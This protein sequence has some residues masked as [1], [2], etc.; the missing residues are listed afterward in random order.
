M[1]QTPKCAT[2]E[3]FLLEIFGAPKKIKEIQ[4]ATGG[5][6]KKRISEIYDQLEGGGMTMREATRAIEDAI[7]AVKSAGRFLNLLR[8]DMSTRMGP[9]NETFDRQKHTHKFANL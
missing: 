1:E 4:T 7:A 2:W 9:I 6:I 5:L 8:N 3:K